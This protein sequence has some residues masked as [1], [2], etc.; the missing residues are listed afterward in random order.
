MGLSNG[1]S[2]GHLKVRR[3][4]NEAGFLFEEEKSYSD[5]KTNTGRL[6]RFDFMVFDDDGNEDFAIEFNGI[7][8]YESVS[9]FG[10]DKAFSRQKY[11]DNRKRKYCQSLGIG[12]VEI[13]YTDLEDFDIGYIMERAYSL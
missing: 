9:F 7:Q 11:N 1:E 10:G 13:P 8:H 2:R 12:L 4:L 6:L 3:L 5:L